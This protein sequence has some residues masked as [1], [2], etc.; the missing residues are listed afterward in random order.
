MKKRETIIETILMKDVC[1]SAGWSGLDHVGV[2][3]E[4]MLYKCE[5]GCSNNIGSND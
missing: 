5:G 3:S 4:T 2:T 1:H